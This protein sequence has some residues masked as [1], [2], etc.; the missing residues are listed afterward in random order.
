MTHFVPTNENYILKTL[1][2]IY[3]PFV[4]SVYVPVCSTVTMNFNTK[5]HC[6]FSLSPHF[7]VCRQCPGAGFTDRAEM[8]FSMQ[9]L[10]GHKHW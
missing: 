9:H 6:Y 4:L 10:A 5:C 8:A 7:Q 3:L 2:R 1:L